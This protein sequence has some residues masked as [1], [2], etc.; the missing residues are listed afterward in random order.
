[1]PAPL[2]HVDGDGDVDGDFNISLDPGPGMS[3][4][5]RVGLASHR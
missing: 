2:D 5:K 3:V 4:A 1:M